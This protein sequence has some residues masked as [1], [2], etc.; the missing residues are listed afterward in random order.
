MSSQQSPVGQ[1]AEQDWSVGCGGNE[2]P[3]AFLPVLSE[4]YESLTTVLQS[5]RDACTKGFV[6]TLNNCSME[7]ALVFP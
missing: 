1:G 5:T 4:I 3:G 7:I 6:S 2:G